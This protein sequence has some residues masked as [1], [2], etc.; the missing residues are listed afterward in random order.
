MAEI[1][2]NAPPVAPPTLEE[3]A[4]WV[5]FEVDDLDGARVGRVQGVFADAD[6]AGPAWLVVAL[7]RRGLLRRRTGPAVAVPVRECAAAASRVWIALPRPAL[8][9]APPVDPA[10]RL[11]REHELAIGAHYGIGEADGRCAEVAGRPQGSVTA[12]P[13]A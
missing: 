2:S 5:G 8:D 1:G 13:A 3:A 10:R 12:Q 7:E 11:L 4:A 6:G 9:S